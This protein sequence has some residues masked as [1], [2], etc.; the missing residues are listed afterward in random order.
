MQLFQQKN[1]GY[2]N[3]PP[4]TLLRIGLATSWLPLDVTC[5]VLIRQ[6]WIFSWREQQ[7]LLAKFAAFGE[8]AQFMGIFLIPYTYFTSLASFITKSY[9]PRGRKTESYILVLLHFGIR[10]VDD[11]R[12]FQSTCRFPDVLRE[13]WA[14]RSHRRV[15][16]GPS[17]GSER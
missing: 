11:P 12:L 10:K 14:E 5:E 16:C 6:I 7:V 13:R 8:T 2:D 15:L 3:H 17:D 9:T 4:S 1:G